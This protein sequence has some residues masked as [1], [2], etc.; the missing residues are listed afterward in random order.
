MQARRFVV[1]GARVERAEQVALLEAA[2]EAGVDVR[3]AAQRPPRHGDLDWH[4]VVDPRAAEGVGGLVGSWVTRAV[5]GAAAPM[6]E[7]L[8][9]DPWLAEQ[10]AGAGGAG[11]GEVQL[12]AL[13]DTATQALSR[14]RRTEGSAGRAVPVRTWD[15]G[16]EEIAE[17]IAARRRA[18]QTGADPAPPPAPAQDGE[19]DR[20]LGARHTVVVVPAPGSAARPAV[21]ALRHPRIA[22]TV[23]DPDAPPGLDL[24]GVD[25]LVLDG[26]GPAVLALGPSR[27]RTVHLRRPTDRRS[28]W[29]HLVGAGWMDAVVDQHTV[30]EPGTV[31]L[32]GLVLDPD[33]ARLLRAPAQEG[34][35]TALALA[36]A[37]VGTDRPTPAL[38]RE[39]SYLTRVTGALTLEREVLLR[40]LE[41]PV[42]GGAPEDL[43]RE[44]LSCVEDTLLE[45]EPGWLPALE[46]KPLEPSPDGPVLHL[47]RVTLPQRCEGD[48]VRGHHTLRALVAAGVDVVGL[49][50]PEEGS[51]GS[52]GTVE[53]VVLDGVRYLVP[54]PVPGGGRTASLQ[55]QAEAVLE[56][57]RREEPSLL[58]VHSGGRGY[59]LGLVGAAVAGATD[60][61][62]IYELRGP[63]EALWTEQE[64]RAERGETFARRMAR[65]TELVSLA[66]AGV[67][68]TGTMRADLLA[69]GGADPEHLLVVPNG[70][71][72]EALAPAPRDDALAERW[73][74]GGVLTV[75][76]VT[77]L[78]H[79]REQVEDLVRAAVM[80]RNEGL[81]VRALVVG[82][83]RRRAR[84]EEMVARW[85]AEDCVVL[86]GAVPQAEVAA[87]YGLLDVLVV[88]RSDERAARLVAP[89]EPYAAMA[90]GVPVVVSAQ[91]ALLEV[92][93]DGD[94]GWSYPPGDAPAL[95]GLLRRLAEQAEERSAV[96]ARARDWV[97]RER[98]WARNAQ[99]Y[100]ALY[101]SVLS[102]PPDPTG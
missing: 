88:P 39:L 25:V 5:R 38:L 1:V 16:A 81:P 42:P 32:L 82:D 24:R 80:L 51:P 69:R 60:L 10:L 15:Q 58:H 99:R 71:D 44:V 93:G 49:A 95:A 45:T 78:D 85:R 77:D 55:Q 48:S 27:P 34:D 7:Q 63:F 100:A 70:V 33:T 97:L 75:G 59:D 35:E 3:V 64:G 79:A 89:L 30:D 41:H 8:D 101:R 21:E 26:L 74:T 46:R 13:D 28:P 6:A 83:G 22:L 14:W 61:P 23:A 54:P 84:L 17:E 96:A 2:R 92:I 86:T 62:W 72:P 98:T 37:L 65:E 76:C 43:V 67:T 91:P 68:P 19:P 94:R 87:V 102:G 20:P 53:E 56:I 18:A 29:R 9:A 66:D 50:A 73:G 47:L 36:S 90:L 11:Q 57:V 31:D 4:R 52:D 12:V 40:Q